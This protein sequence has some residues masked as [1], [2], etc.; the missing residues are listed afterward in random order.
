MKDNLFHLHGGNIHTYRRMIHHMD[1]GIGWI[2]D[3][4]RRA[5][6]RRRHARRLHQ[7][8][9]RR[10]L[11]RQLAAG[12]RQ[13]GPHRRRHPRALDRALAGAHRAA[14]ASATQLCMTMDWSAT[15]LDAAGVGADPRYPLDGVSLLPVLRRSGAR[16]RR[17]RCTGA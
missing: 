10:A 7:R 1:E 3:A 13:D 4:L 5:R 8:Q 9:R 15:M 12:G 2:L 14:A 17:G 6:R 11:L 16:V